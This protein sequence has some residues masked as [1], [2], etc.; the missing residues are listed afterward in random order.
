M[1]A[2]KDTQVTIQNVNLKIDPVVKESAESVLA[3]MGLNMS[4]Y[5]GMCLRQLAQDREIPFTQ[6]ADPEFWATEYRAY[7]TKRIVDSGIIQP[8]I[9]LY[10]EIGKLIT[11]ISGE[12]EA[13]MLVAEIDGTSP[14]V[15]E[16]ANDMLGDVTFDKSLNATHVKVSMLLESVSGIE[17]RFA[18][19]K[20]VKP[21]TAYRETLESIDGKIL[22]GCFEIAENLDVNILE[23]FGTVFDLDTTEDEG[24][25]ITRENSVLLVDQ[26]FGYAVE[27]YSEN[28]DSIVLR[29]TGQV[30]GSALA[31]ALS[32]ASAAQDMLSK[33]NLDVKYNTGVA[34]ALLDKNKGDEQGD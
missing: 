2:T 17:K 18:G 34:P 7:K 31:I 8:A 4:A 21:F 3:N 20:D 33:C 22:D 23:L 12:I 30:G 24:F 6:K 16:L 13:K 1:K 29:Y 25:T 28:P 19:D 32:A 5:I 11:G 14:T 27:T 10:T 9:N 15:I 26:L